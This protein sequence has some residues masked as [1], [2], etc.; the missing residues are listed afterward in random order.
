MSFDKQIYKTIYEQSG[1]GDLICVKI[2]GCL[3]ESGAEADIAS[4]IIQYTKA[5]EDGNFTLYLAQCESPKINVRGI[6]YGHSVNHIYN[7]LDIDKLLE[8]D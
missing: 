1:G 5:L 3:R 4:R 6:T 8:R 7:A 2:Y